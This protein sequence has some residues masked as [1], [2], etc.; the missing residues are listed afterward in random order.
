[1]DAQRL[2]HRR[3]SAPR[4]PRRRSARSATAA[5]PSSASM[6]GY[7]MEEVRRTLIEQLRRERRGR[8]EQR[9]CRRPVG[10]HLDDPG[11]AGR[12]R[13]GAA[14][15]PRQ[16][17]RRPRL[18]RHRAQHRRRR[19]L[20][21]RSCAA[22]RSAPAFPTGARRWCWRRPAA[23][24][25]IG[26]ADGTTGT[27]A[28][29]AA[30]QPKRGGGGAGLRPSCGPGMI[31]IVKQM[32][33]DSYAL[34]SIPEIGGGFVAEEVAHRPRAGDAGRVRR[35]RLVATT[36]PPRRCASRARRSSRSSMS[37]ALENGMTPGLDHRRCAVLRVAGRG[38]GQQMLPQLRRRLCRAPRRCAGA[39]SSRAT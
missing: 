2:H 26:F 35:H 11:D 30:S 38:A 29:S 27:L 28:A 36:A 32:G 34:R 9:L 22:R 20:A 21:R 12:R 1:M 17:R 4:R 15:R 19:R 3:R 14:R 16:V 13:R 25:E 33:A 8:P 37:A 7:F 6:G 31:I 23:R 18:A 10:A 39:S 5:T 24:R